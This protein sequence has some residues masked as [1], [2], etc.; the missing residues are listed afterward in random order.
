M[1]ITRKQI[2][3][4]VYLYTLVL[5]AVCLP[6]SVYVTSASIILLTINWAAEGRFREKWEKFAPNRA[7]QLFLLIFVLQLLGLFWSE[8]LD[9]GLNL[10]KIKIPLLALPVIIATSRSLDM[11]QVRRILL[12]FSL[13]VFVTTLASLLKL[14]GWFPEGINGYR[15]L[16][17]FT[18][19][20]WFS[21]LLVMSMLIS[22]Y[23]L[24]LQRSQVSVAERI[25]H[26]VQ[27]IWLPVF[28]ILLKSLTGIFVAVSLG[29]LILLRLVFEIRDPVYR[30]ML[31]VGVIMIPVFSYL[32]LSH[33]VEKFYTVEALVPEDLE[34][35]TIEGN[36]YEHHPDNREIENGHYVWLYVC[37]SE[38]EREW[39]K[40]S[41]I[42]F[43]GRTRSG[44][45][46]R[47]TL[48]R[49]LTSRDLR[50]DAA[51]V[52]QLSKADIRAIER[53]T[54]NHIYLN[55]FR[56][57]PRIY[58]VIWEFDRYGL[59][60]PPNDKSV[61]QRY[62]YLQAA[63]S[64]AREHLLF[65]VGNGDVLQAFKQY[66]Q[67]HNSPLDSQQ[68]RM[69]HNQYLSEW[70]SFGLVGLLV[71]LAA[72]VGPLF[73]ARR[74]RSFLATGVLMIILISMLGGGTLDAATGVAFGG[75]FY[76]LFLFGPDF[77]WLRPKS[78]GTDG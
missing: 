8:N 41:D 5:I 50:K 24:I 47:T 25:Y 63:W 46:L 61:V 30:F 53:G 26:L 55:R 48:I 37:D 19:H 11:Q 22:F 31:L 33:A 10:V 60:Y 78:S 36:P 56:L 4:Q 68:R 7:L 40:V 34:P 62:L 18:K 32:Y 16:S 77:P 70:I 38:L 27:L 44:A 49:F 1:Q 14:S 69:V 51:G 13:A 21:L 29:F 42:D 17:L 75:L 9:Y 73:L 72:L 35:Y 67:T 15:D 12:L 74:Q 23:F 76:S 57:Y 28:L 6:L 58:E 66:Y 54:A 2:H 45:S 3:E 43:H 64:I 20:I 71:F 65:G 39:N 52:K 59:G